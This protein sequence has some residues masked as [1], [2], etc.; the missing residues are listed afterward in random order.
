MDNQLTLRWEDIHPPLSPST[1]R[2]LSGLGFCEATPVQ[3]SVIPHFLSNKDIV[4]EAVT[5]SGKTLAF[6]IPILEIISGIIP[7]EDASNILSL[8]V[9]P[10]RE[11]A[12]QIDS[13]LTQCIKEFP[14]YRSLLVVGGYSTHKDIS[15]L[16]EVRP[17][18]LIGTPGKLYDLLQQKDN[19]LSNSLR[20]LEVLVLDEADRLLSMGF[21][22]SVTSLL[23]SL[24]K[25]RRTGLFSATQTNEVEKLIRVGLRNPIRINVTQLNSSVSTPISLRNYYT[26]TP[27]NLKLASLI[28]FL[29]EHLGAKIILFLATCVGVDYFSRIL[30]EELKDTKVLS[31]HGKMKDRRFSIFDKFRNLESGILMCTDVM[32]RGIDIPSVDWVVQFDPPSMASFFVH[33][34]GRTAR[35]GQEGRSLLFLLPNEK[36]YIAFIQYNQKV[37]LESLAINT[38]V[39]PMTDRIRELSMKEREVYEKGLRAF[40][41]FIQFYAKHECNLIFRLKELDFGGLA[42][43]YGLLHLPSMPELRNKRVHSTGFLPHHMDYATIRYKDKV[44]EKQRLK[45]ISEGTTKKKEKIRKILDLNPIRKKKLNK[46]KM[47]K[48]ISHKFSAEELDELTKEAR[49]LKKF[50]MGKISKKEFERLVDD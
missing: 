36:E 3:A 49:L 29:K 11:L 40:V 35:C 8:I 22:E 38:D 10:T 45:R 1:L 28:A 43:G 18:I 5:G 6:L 26:L 30:A 13:V 31:I 16:R 9:T 15:C 12:Y 7:V 41:S 44:R 19:N 37:E 32:A 25:Q 39:Q 42:M 23:K 17:H 27:A 48:Q 4:A 21:E 34:V 20:S 33:R 24:P 14:N 47:S 50:K 2:A 46:K